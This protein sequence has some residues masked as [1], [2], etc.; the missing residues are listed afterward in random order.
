V[1]DGRGAGDLHVSVRVRTPVK[2]SKEGRE[3]LES[4]ARSGDETAADEERS[5]F[6]KVKDLFH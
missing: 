3:A 1:R 4:L 2:L 5:I 6:E